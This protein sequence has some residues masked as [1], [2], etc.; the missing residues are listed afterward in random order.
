MSYKKKMAKEIADYIREK[1]STSEP[2]KERKDFHPS[3]IHDE[4][5]KKKNR[6]QRRQTKQDL[7]KGDYG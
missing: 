7:K 3:R 2:T 1:L 6:K 4:S 5:K